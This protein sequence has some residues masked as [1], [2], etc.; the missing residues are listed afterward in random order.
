MLLSKF[1]PAAVI[2]NKTHQTGFSLVELMVTLAIAAIL[3][4]IG[5]PSMIDLI[6]DARLAS[7]SDMLVSTL[8]LARTEA[9][10]Q[11]NNFR[12]CPSAAPNTDAL[13]TC[14]AGAGAWST[15]WITIYQDTANAGAAKAI[16]QRS[17]AS[18]DLTVTTAATSVE[19]SGTIGSA[20]AATSFVLCTPNRKQH[21]VDVSLSGHI[22][23][24]IGTT[25]CP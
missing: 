1:S 16:T 13:L 17:V 20:T 24:R 4:V 19:F 15:G 12:V 22:S 14:A 6:R 5:V 8:N 3:L 2:T 7:Q 18:S 25:V 10:K 9:V 23:K 21:L 11:R